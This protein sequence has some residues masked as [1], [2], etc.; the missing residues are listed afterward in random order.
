MTEFAAIMFIATLIVVMNGLQLLIIIVK[1]LKV[2]AKLDRIVVFFGNERNAISSNV[3]DVRVQK[4]EIKKELIKI[5]QKIHD[6]TCNNEK[7]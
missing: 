3:N 2:W 6:I 5:K 7:F 4:E 1:D